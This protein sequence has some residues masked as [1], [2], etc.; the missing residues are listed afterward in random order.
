MNLSAI[1]IQCYGF[2]YFSVL[3]KIVLDPYKPRIFVLY[4]SCLTISLFS[5]FHWMMGCIFVGK[6]HLH[7]IIQFLLQ[8]EQIC[9][10]KSGFN[11]E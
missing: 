8:H 10:V 4:S 11:F 1:H 6:Q 5:A 9:N 2:C 7:N 3:S